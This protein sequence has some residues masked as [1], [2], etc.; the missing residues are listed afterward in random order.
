MRGLIST[1]WFACVFLLVSELSGPANAYLDP[2]TGSMV[3]QVILGGIVAALTLLK[4]YWRRVKAFLT[5]RQS[6]D[7]SSL[8][9]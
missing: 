9:D 1:L 3:I 4:L 2:G 6:N 8:S 7:S 5:G